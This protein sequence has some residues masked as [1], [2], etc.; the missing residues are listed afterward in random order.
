MYDFLIG[1]GMDQQRRAI[2][3]LPIIAEFNPRPLQH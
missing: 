3:L 2:S 1:A